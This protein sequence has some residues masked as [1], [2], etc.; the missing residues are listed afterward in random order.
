MKTNHYNTQGCIISVNILRY[1]DD[2]IAGINTNHNTLLSTL[3]S[4]NVKLCLV[5]PVRSQFTTTYVSL[6]KWPVITSV[7]ELRIHQL[8]IVR[9]MNDWHRRAL[10]VNIRTTAV[11]VTIFVVLET[12]ALNIT[13]TRE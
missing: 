11:I 13:T 9:K 1:T 4:V 5:G 2:V 3:A 6:C 12:T 7:L 10:L 8:P